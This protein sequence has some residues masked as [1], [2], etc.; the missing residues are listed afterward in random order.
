MKTFKPTRRAALKAAAV[1]TAAPAVAKAQTGGSGPANRDLVL[2]YRQPAAQWVEA[3]PVG[4]GRIGAMVFGGVE[5][6]RLQL[7]EN[8]LW[9]GGPYDPANPE[10]LAAL[11]PEQAEVVRLS[12]FSDKPHSQISLELGVPLGTVKSRLR[13]AMNRLR[14]ALD[15]R[16]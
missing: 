3:L 12:F 14:A 6:E 11:P 1:L 7:N 8:S 16:P 2:W 4:N 10:A 15:E 13:L 5:H 9:A